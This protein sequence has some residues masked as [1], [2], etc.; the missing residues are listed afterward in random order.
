[1]LLAFF[2]PNNKMKT[3]EYIA[4]LTVLSG[5]ASGSVDVK[6][7]PGRITHVAAFFRDYS[8]VNAGFVRASIKDSNGEEVSKMQALE[9]Y[10]DR[11]GGY[12]IGK[13]PLPV[14]GGNFFTYTVQA[15]VAFTADFMSELVFVYQ[16]ENQ[17]P[18]YNPQCQ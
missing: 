6:L 17:Q 11:D 15:T 5:S 18:G 16:I 9:N 1:M 12:L 14:E 2:N 7:P 4:Q 8:A 3:Q 13:K 10:R